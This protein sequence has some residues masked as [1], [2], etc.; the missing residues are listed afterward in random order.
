MTDWS[1]QQRQPYSETIWRPTMSPLRLSINSGV[2]P[3]TPVNNSHSYH[4]GNLNGLEAPSQEPGK[5]PNSLLYSTWGEEVTVTIIPLRKYF[6][7]LIL[8][9]IQHFQIFHVCV[10]DLSLQTAGHWHGG[11]LVP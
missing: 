6:Q 1:F 11:T 9:L 2:V 5:R 4:L 3:G 10:I 7:V 8:H